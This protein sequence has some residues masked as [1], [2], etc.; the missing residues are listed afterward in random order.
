MTAGGVVTAVGGALGSAEGATNT[1]AGGS[2]VAHVINVPVAGA[3]TFNPGEYLYVEFWLRKSAGWAPGEWTRLRINNAGHFIQMTA[4]TSTLLPAP[5]TLYTGNVSAQLGDVNPLQVTNS[6]PRFSWSNGAVATVDRQRVELYNTPLTG[7]VGLWKLDGNAN[8]SGPF[9]YTGTPVGAP[10]YAARPDYGSALQLNGTSQ[11]INVGAVPAVR[12]AAQWTVEAWV[13]PSSYPNGAGVFSQLTA[14]SNVKVDLGYGIDEGVGGS[15]DL[16]CGYY[17][18]ADGWTVAVEPRTPDLNTWAHLACVYDGTNITIYRNGEQVAQSTPAFAPDTPSTQPFTIGRRHDFGGS[19]DYFPG[20]IDDVRFSNVARSYD[21]IRGYYATS[22]AHD[23]KLWDSDPADTG[24]AIGA[25][26]L[27]QA[28]CADIRVGSSGTSLG[29]VLRPNARYYARAKL[30]TTTGTWTDWSA[31]DWFQ[32]K[33]DTLSLSLST[34]GYADASRDLT[35]GALSFGT[36]WPS[37]AKEIGPVGSGQTLPGAAVIASVATDTDSVLS[38]SATTWTS[39][40]DTM[41]PGAL[42]W[43]HYSVAESWTSFTA[44]PTA[45]EPDLLTGAST[46][47]YDLQLLPPALTI[48]GSYTTSVTFTLTA[49]P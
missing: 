13:N 16:K 3:V 25:N 23:T 29:S 44:G 20:Q 36:A 5:S 28:R 10:T 31:P 15:A 46:L 7:V 49:S 41:P 11:R 27:A 37:V 1:N 4:P 18:T 38:S 21:E 26:C 40:G 45:I 12:N 14:T 42:S 47:Q 22:L 33:N 17:N 30:M 9:G 34:L 35:P 39:G 2:P 32:T 6:R 24:Q 43:K 8:D 19:V 48:P